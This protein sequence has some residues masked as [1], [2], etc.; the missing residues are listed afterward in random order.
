MECRH[1]EPSLLQQGL[2]RGWNVIGWSWQQPSKGR[3]QASSS[4]PT[5]PYR[6]YS[7]LGTMRLGP[8]TCSS[9]AYG[10][11]S[12][13]V[14]ARCHTCWEFT[15]YWQ[16]V[17]CPAPLPIPLAPLNQCPC[18][19]FIHCQVPQLEQS[20]DHIA[21]QTGGCHSKIKSTKHLKK[22]TV[23]TANYSLTTTNSKTQL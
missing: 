3:Q 10:C 2:R 6:R 13:L 22:P 14:A 9:I 16:R 4:V 18:L 12:A 7:H 5:P 19:S 15:K 1:P 21:R 11:R 8:N 17:R 20:G 23:I